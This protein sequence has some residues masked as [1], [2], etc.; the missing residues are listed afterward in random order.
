MNCEKICQEFDRE[1]FDYVF[2]MSALQYLNERQYFKNISHILRTDGKVLIF[3]THNIGYY[4]R[5][6]P[7]ELIQKHLKSVVSFSAVILGI[8]EPAFSKGRDHVVTYGTSRGMALKYGIELQ[9][10][11]F[12]T[13]CHQNYQ[14]KFL[15]LPSVF[16]MLGTKKKS[17]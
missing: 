1:S 15:N 16:N 12:S 13:L 14:E 11:E 6:I 2:T 7:K 10:V 5:N 8:L 9:L 4:I 17:L 3:W